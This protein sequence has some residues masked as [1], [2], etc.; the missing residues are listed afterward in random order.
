MT[1][2]IEKIVS[3]GRVEYK[4]NVPFLPVY[5]HPGRAAIYIKES[6]MPPGY[7]TAF[8]EKKLKIRI[9]FPE[10]SSIGSASTF[11]GND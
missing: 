9:S 3:I 4:E 5:T 7:Q 10:G 8:Q 6:D 2:K 11:I 1:E